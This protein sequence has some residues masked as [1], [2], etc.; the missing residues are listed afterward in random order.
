[1]LEL[2]SKVFSCSL[3]SAKL[4]TQFESMDH[5]SSCSLNR[6]SNVEC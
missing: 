6:A 4:L 1:M 5:F 2:G 3:K